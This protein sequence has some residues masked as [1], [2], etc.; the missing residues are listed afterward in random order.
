[1]LWWGGLGTLTALIFA[2]A[3]VTWLVNIADAFDIRFESLPVNAYLARHLSLLYAA[4]GVMFL[5]LSRDVIRYRPMIRLIGGGGVGFGL[6][7]AMI[8]VM[9]DMPW[10]WTAGESVSTIVAGAVLYALASF[11]PEPRN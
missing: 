3:P 2:V 8:D 10:Y 6:A 4:V 11:K 5:Q 9:S 7:Q 1:M